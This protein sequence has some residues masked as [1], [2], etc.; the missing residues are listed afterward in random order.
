MSTVRIA[1]L[2]GGFSTE[3]DT[4]LDPWLLGH[5]RS[6][7]PRVC[8]VPTASGDARTYAD[9]FRTAF[10]R[11]DCAPSVLSLF[12][13]DRDAAALR[14][15]VLTQDVLYVGGGS[16]ANLLAVWR[17]HGVDLL[18]REAAARG[19]LLCGISAG[20]NCWADA[21]LTDSYGP[22]GVLADGLGLLPGSFCPHYDSEPGRRP[23]YRAAVASGALPGGWALDDGAAALFS[24]RPGTTEPPEPVEIVS[25]LPGAALHR[26]APDGHG[27]STESTREGRPLD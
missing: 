24:I 12:A 27:G 1:V 7:R 14:E 21:S 16:T 2:G 10:G 3:G 20:A 26:V 15:Q 6:P 8:F 19:A 22:L 17:V 5:A 13:R 4:V 11:L 23:A 25:R 18:L 9:A